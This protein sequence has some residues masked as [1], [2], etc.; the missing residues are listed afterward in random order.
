MSWAPLAGSDPVPGDSAAIR[1]SAASLVDIAEALSSAAGRVRAARPGTPWVGLAAER[2][3]EQRRALPSALDAVG[4][5]CHATADA[6]RTYAVRLDDAQAMAREALWR[7]RSAVGDIEAA[8]R[9]IQ[10]MRHHAAAAS[11]EATTWNAANPDRPP[12]SPA[13]WTGPDWPVRLAAAQAELEAARALLRRAEAARDEAARATASRVESAGLDGE[14]L[15]HLATG[16]LGSLRGLLDHLVGLGGAGELSFVVTPDGLV[17]HTRESWQLEALR[18][19]GIDP[20]AWDTGLGLDRIDAEA[21][22]AWELYATLH[23]SNPELFQW[24]GMAKL[25]GGTFYAGFQDLNVLRRALAVPGITAERARELIRLAFPHLPAAALHPLLHAAE[26]NLDG[27][28]AD[29]RFVEETFLRMQRNIFDDL[30]WQHVAYAAGGMEAMRQLRADGRILEQHLLAWRDIDSGDPDRVAAGNARM[31]RHEQERIIGEDYDRIRDHSPTTWA[32]TMGMS[33]IAES[34]IPGGRPFR[35]VV[36]YRVSV[37][38]GLPDRIPLPGGGIGL[39]G[40]DRIEVGADLPLHN[41][42]IFENRWRWI[43]EDMLP[44]YVRLLD[45]GEAAALIATPIED[46]ADERRLLPLPYEPQP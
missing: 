33:V 40:P 41:V 36:P 14:L 9:G 11:R 26:R 12:R 22:A 1:A 7:A 8:R 24:A 23:A 35:E 27:L 17:L 6:L 4:R 20:A 25:A 44:A 15:A 10:A 2:F 34:P 31:L 16:V 28:V 43:D 21:R 19:A 45:D 46:L 29:L 5:R 30:A 38:V 42:S 37:T 3:D 18:M 13:P 32:L 39:P